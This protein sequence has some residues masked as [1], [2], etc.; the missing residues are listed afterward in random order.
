VLDR[1]SRQNCGYVSFDQCLKAGDLIGATC[2]PDRTTAL[3]T[4]DGPY[5]TYHSIYPGMTGA[6]IS[7]THGHRVPFVPS[8][9]ASMPSRSAI[10]TAS[11]SD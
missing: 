4:D 10:E 8:G 11:A 3:I 1:D 9:A 5:R 6:T 2:R 7:E